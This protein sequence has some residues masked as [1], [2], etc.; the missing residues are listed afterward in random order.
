MAQLSGEYVP[1]TSQ[2]VRDQIEEY[3]SSGGTKGHTL[4]DTGIPVIIVAMR[5]AKSGAVRKIA[6]MRVEH[7]GSYALVASKGGAPDN[8]N[9]YHNLLA[10]P[11]EVTV[12]DGP[13]PFFVKVREVTGNEYDEWWSRSASVFPQYETYKAKTDRVIPI[14]VAEPA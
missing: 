13:E 5:G 11:T 3:E 9:W 6:L 7:E 12:Q 14:L 8:P 2:W 10:N 1:S 4:L